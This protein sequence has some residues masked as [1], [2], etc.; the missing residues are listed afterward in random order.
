MRA[1]LEFVAALVVV[2]LPAAAADDHQNLLLR[3]R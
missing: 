1:Y 2:Q 3:K